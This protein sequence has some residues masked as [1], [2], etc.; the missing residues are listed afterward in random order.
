MRENLEGVATCDLQ[1]ALGAM[2]HPIKRGVCFLR[3]S[4]LR[5]CDSERRAVSATEAAEWARG[6]GYQ[7]FE[8]SA[9][10]GDGVQELFAA[11]FDETLRSVAAATAAAAVLPAVP[12]TSAATAVGGGGGVG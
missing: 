9:Q 2:Y 5:Q 7:Y 10:S 6:R 3:L 11:V 1:P 8:V 4:P 12:T